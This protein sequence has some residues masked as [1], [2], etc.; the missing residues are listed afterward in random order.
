MMA[1]RLALA[2]PLAAALLAAPGRADDPP[3]DPG[4][5]AAGQATSPLWIDPFELAPKT[6]AGWEGAS[7]LALRRSQD[8]WDSSL[9]ERLRARDQAR[10]L[11][12]TGKVMTAFGRSAS[13]SGILGAWSGGDP[14]GMAQEATNAFLGDVVSGLGAAAAIA[15][16]PATATMGTIVAV[17]IAGSVV[18]STAYDDFVKPGVDA[19][20][21]RGVDFDSDIDAMNQRIAGARRWVAEADVACADARRAIADAR[22][23]T[24]EAATA[25]E[26]VRWLDEESAALEA[27]L[28]GVRELVARARESASPAELAAENAATRARAEGLAAD[29]GGYADEACRIAGEMAGT[30]QADALRIWNRADR[31]LDQRASAVAADA[32]AA[33]EEARDRAARVDEIDAL[34]REAAAAAAG[35]ASEVAALDAHVAGARARLGQAAEQVRRGAGLLQEATAATED[36]HSLESRAIA[37]LDKPPWN[38]YQSVRL[39]LDR[40][41]RPIDPPFGDLEAAADAVPEAEARVARESRQL[42]WIAA[43]V[44]DLRRELASA[45]PAADPGATARAHDAATRAEEARA[46]AERAAARASAC[47][48]QA[49]S[50]AEAAPEEGEPSSA[51]ES[52][53]ADGGWERLGGV[54][55]VGGSATPRAPEPPAGPSLGDLLAAAETAFAGC[56]FAAARSAIA[57]ARALAPEDA[58]AAEVEARIEAKAERQAAAIAALQAAEHALGRG[59]RQPALAALDRAADAA[60]DCF[61]QQVSAV[62]GEVREGLSARRQEAD[63]RARTAVGGL[64]GTM[65][66]AWNAG[67]GGPGAG[68]GSASGGSGGGG[69]AG[70]APGGAEPD[71]TR[72]TGAYCSITGAAAAAERFLLFRQRPRP[73]VA[74]YVI[75]ATTEDDEASLASTTG[76]EL[77][78]RHSS[79]GDAVAAARRACPNP[80]QSSY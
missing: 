38:R 71:G 11:G 6:D 35:A 34:R 9:A 12:R 25:E 23:A 62:S 21:E 15:L 50:R 13:Y 72:A 77:L 55:T 78:S 74:N 30:R 33:L 75:V 45:G 31:Y 68:G 54:E 29:A 58:Y 70:A 5:P 66:G 1:P 19:A 73:E 79:Y 4:P 63:Q 37:L 48:E 52:A 24:G 51:A 43:T 46:A 53:A 44:A 61:T 49:R 3:A 67:M 57:R 26:T 40:E 59:A 32:A 17:G 69:T 2:L 7:E 64:L 10:A 28:A 76:M 41:V 56:N 36:C 18:A 14:A 27:R 8:V 39:V 60:P 65:I 47:A 22:R 20:F 42:E 16:L 80:V